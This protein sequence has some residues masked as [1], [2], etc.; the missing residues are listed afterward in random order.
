MEKLNTIIG[1]LEKFNTEED[2]YNYLYEARFGNGLYCPH[3]HNKKVYSFSDGKTFKC[4]KCRKRF[5]IRTNTLFGGSKIS[6]KKWFLAMYLL[7]SN[8]KGISSIQLAEQLGVTQKTAWYIDHRIRETFKQD[9]NKLGGII[10]ID[11]TYIGGKEK[12]KHKSKKQKGTQG[13][14]L[15]TKT[16]VV[17]VVEREGKLKAIQVKTVQA[18][19]IKGILDKYVSE[20]KIIAD[21]YRIYDSITSF[22]V[23]HSQGKYVIDDCHT[24]TI[25]GFWG[26]LKRGL[27]GIY[28][29]VSK[30]H[31]QKYL[32]EF[33]FK[34]N[35][36]DSKI[37]DKF[38]MLLQNTSNTRITYNKLIA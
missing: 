3:C 13:R 14:S 36:R 12:N 19:T 4:S 8:K 24:N 7:A 27:I 34:Y 23:N 22:R 26:L 31:L 29:N 32:D 10:E 16:A 30:K 28:H 25:E 35:N 18:N 17:G 37:Y 5:N 9:E 6:L 38:Y 15:K 21:E 20:G 2:C 33:V 1:F 11:E